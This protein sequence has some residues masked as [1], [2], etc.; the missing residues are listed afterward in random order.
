MFRTKIE[1][2]WTAIRKF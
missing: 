2:N 1:V